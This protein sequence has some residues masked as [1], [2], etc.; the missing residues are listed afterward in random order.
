MNASLQLEHFNPDGLKHIPQELLM[1][2]Q[3]ITWVA[4][5][6]D[7]KTGKFDKFPRGKDGSGKAWPKPE[8]WLGNLHDAVKRAQDRGHSGPGIVLPAKVDDLH[9]VAFDWDGVDFKDTARMDE[10]MTDWDSL[11]QPYLETS[12]SGKHSFY[13]LPP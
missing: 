9:V 5:S 1:L 3:A 11:G 4:G 8:Q 10:I 2:P 13:L 7:P 6:P 12:P